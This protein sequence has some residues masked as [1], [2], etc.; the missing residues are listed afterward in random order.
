MRTLNIRMTKRT[1][2]KP[3]ATEIQNDRLLSGCSRSLKQ[4]G[5]Q[6]RKDLTFLP[7]QISY[8]ITQNIFQV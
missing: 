5:E 2:N 1:P 7:C 3:T 4:N 6:L 8:V